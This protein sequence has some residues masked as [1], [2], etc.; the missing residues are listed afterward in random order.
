MAHRV[1]NILDGKTMLARG[2][3]VKVAAACHI[4]TSEL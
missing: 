4:C 3:K 2:E 1:P